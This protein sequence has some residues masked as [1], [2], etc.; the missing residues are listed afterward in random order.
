MEAEVR[1]MENDLY[2]KGEKEEFERRKREFDARENKTKDD[3]EPLNRDEH[4]RQKEANKEALIKQKKYYAHGYHLNKD[5]EAEKITSKEDKSD[6][7]INKLGFEDRIEIDIDNGI[8]YNFDE[9][10][11]IK[12]PTSFIA[13]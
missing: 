13:M 12:R 1:K 10:G 3:E 7:L 11:P 8:V 6:V 5:D 4:D 9:K 2:L